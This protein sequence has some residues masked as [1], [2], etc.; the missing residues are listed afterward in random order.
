MGEPEEAASWM[1][2]RRRSS[3]IVSEMRW[4]W[5]DD[6][7]NDLLYMLDSILLRVEWALLFVMVNMLTVLPWCRVELSV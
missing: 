7:K 4:I 2:G 5:G 3:R 6:C 1:M